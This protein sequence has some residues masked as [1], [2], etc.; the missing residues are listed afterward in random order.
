MRGVWK[1]EEEESERK[2]STSG[3]PSE[4]K[5]KAESICLAFSLPLS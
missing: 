1:E 4:R 5:E 2:G 3:E